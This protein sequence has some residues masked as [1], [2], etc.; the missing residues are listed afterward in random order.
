MPGEA[1]IC[2]CCQQPALGTLLPA[3]PDHPEGAQ[4]AVDHER[5]NGYRLM[6]MIGRAAADSSAR[7]EAKAATR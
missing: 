2:D 5:C 7:L 4:V 1:R 6:A 3:D